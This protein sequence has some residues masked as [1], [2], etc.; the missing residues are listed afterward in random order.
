MTIMPAN[1]WH[2]YFFV[3]RL[4]LVEKEND[5]LKEKLKKIEEKKMKL[6][7]YI[8]D[9]VDD[10]KRKIADVVD[11]HKINM[12]AMRLK[13]RKIRKYAINKGLVSLC[14]R[15]NGYLSCEFDRICCCI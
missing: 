3:E 14:C 12:D 5:D 11:V 1:T 15:S 9:V 6:E 10:H 4:N 8:A 7:L 2:R 13:N